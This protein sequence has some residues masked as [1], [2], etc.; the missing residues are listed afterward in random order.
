MVKFAI[1]ESRTG[2][3]KTKKKMT[4]SNQLTSIRKTDL[5]TTPPHPRRSGAN[6]SN[7]HNALPHT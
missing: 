1:P 5:F 4:R 2:H 6:I 7:S 3:L